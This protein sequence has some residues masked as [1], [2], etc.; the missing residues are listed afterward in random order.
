MN[1]KSGSGGLG[2]AIVLGVKRLRRMVP[3]SIVPIGKGGAVV[4]E[5]TGEHTSK[6]LK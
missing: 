1:S 4:V 3:V 5:L 6:D 2:T